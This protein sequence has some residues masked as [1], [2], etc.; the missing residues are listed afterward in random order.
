MNIVQSI[1][2]CNKPD[3]LKENFGWLSPE[4]NIMSW[5]LSCLQFR[6]YY[7]NVTLYADTNAAKILIDYLH[8][9][10][11]EVV[12]KLDELNDYHPQ[13]WAL[14]KIFTYSLQNEPFLHVDGDVFIWKK[15]ED[16]LLTGKLIAQNLEMGTDLYEKIMESLESSLTYFPTEILEDRKKNNPI[17]AYNAGIFG[18]ADIDFF[19]KYTHK[20]FEFV[21][22]N[23]PNLSNINVYDF[24]IFFEQYLF[25]CLVS[26]KS[27]DVNVLFEKL[28]KDDQY[29]GFGNF[30]NVPY[31][32]QY[33]H[34]IGG[35]KRDERTCVQMASRLRQDYPDYYYKIIHL[36]KKE[37]LSL[38]KDYYYFL[39]D[40]SEDALLKRSSKL[41]E[42]YA[43]DIL[44][45][46]H[47]TKPILSDDIKTENLLSEDVRKKLPEWK[48]ADL[49]TFCNNLNNI[50]KNKFSHISNDYL[51][52]RDLNT[53]QY[54]QYVFENAESIFQ[55]K[56]IAAPLVELLD[57]RNDWSLVFN[58]Q[59]SVAKEKVEDFFSDR[60]I[61]T[62]LAIVP[63]CNKSNFSI[64]R[65]DEVDKAILMLLKNEVTILDLL[66]NLMDNWKRPDF[67]NFQD[68]LER[69]IFDK[70]KYGIS[71]KA[72][73][74]LI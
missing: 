37:K 62:C 15:F 63:E 70:I 25:Y 21:D 69:I 12:C 72:I 6:Q 27:I 22:K 20:A 47:T 59:G 38:S 14:P 52:G 40:I 8:L 13:L 29:I 3:F 48:V 51:Y 74:A 5:T 26:Q 42:L 36:F 53:T 31:K 60:E 54:F 46:N 24:N 4:Y 50:I 43:S 2:S 18:G 45:S 61:K 67:K 1:W 64:A 49:N 68:I 11:S 71:C 35:N 17:Y 56:I 39:D 7:D 28:I 23:L 41:K 16:S 19:K 44:Q 34:L 73:K 30:V 65:M 55:K 10:Y 9:P 58:K 33:L 57:C 66:N 32:K